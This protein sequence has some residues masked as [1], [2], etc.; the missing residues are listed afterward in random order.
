MGQEIEGSRF[1]QDDFQR[2]FDRLKQETE[3]LNQYLG[4]GRFD[5]QHTVAGFELEAWITDKDCQP[6]PINAE[7]LK[8]MN[9]PLVC[10]ELASFNVEFNFTPQKLEGQALSVIE[11]EMRQLWQSGCDTANDLGGQLVMIG[12]LPTAE[13]RHLTMDNIS[14]MNRFHA[15]NDQ[16]LKLRQCRP[17]ELNILGRDHLRLTHMDVMFESATTSF[18]IHLQVPVD[19]AVRAYNASV[20]ASAMTVAVSANSPYLCGKDLWAETRIPLFEQAVEVGGYEHAAHGPLRRVS[21]GS[22]YAKQS[23]FE[24]FKHNLDH[25][26]ILLPDDIHDPAE[27]F[28]HVRLHNGTLW[29]W[30]RP[31]IGVEDDGNYHIRIEH[32]VVPSGPSVRD[33]IANSAFYY[34]LA[35]YLINSE[36]PPEN[37]LPF[38]QARDNFYNAAKN[39]LDAHV[40]WL[41]GNKYSIKTLILDK[42]L[43]YA[44]DGLQQSMVDSADI[45]LYLDII[46][47]RTDKGLNGAAWQRGFVDKFGKD[48]QS[49]TAAYI[50]RQNSGEPVNNWDY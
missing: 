31:L 11:K 21:F 28:S 42:L 46:R 20:I 26:P 47:K 30:N 5:N 48:M 38:N 2:F 36:I 17:L 37:Q 43:E 33:A 9:N 25:F 39:G 29:R 14:S 27:K 41:D 35:T 4:S 24:C 40:V 10:P 22:G 19:L 7:F 23:I 44:A 50:D 45:D 34:G 3:L 12:I 49:L 1:T 16:V 18:Q 32:R 13:D 6:A 8:R 15:L